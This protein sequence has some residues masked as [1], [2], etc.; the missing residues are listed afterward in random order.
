MLSVTIVLKWPRLP[1]VLVS[2]M[3]PGKSGPSGL[4]EDPNC[5][6]R[7]STVGKTSWSI[8]QLVLKKMKIVILKTEK[9]LLLVALGSVLIEPSLLSVS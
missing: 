3:L 7:L 2:F 6:M 1:L 8:S 5:I 4:D 9:K